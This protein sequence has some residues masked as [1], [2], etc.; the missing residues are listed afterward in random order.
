MHLFL[1][2]NH[3]VGKS[4]VINAAVE[5][6]P[7][8][9]MGFHTYISPVDSQGVSTVHISKYGEEQ[10]VDAPIVSVRDKREYTFTA[11]PEVFDTYGVN[12]LEQSK[13]AKLIVMDELGFMEK[14]ALLFQEK[15]IEVLNSKVPVLGVIKRDNYPFLNK[16]RSLVKTLEVTL[17]NREEIIEEVKSW[18]K[19]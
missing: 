1:M 12:I 9:P 5:N 10:K 16:V 8:T 4:T 18:L 14:E 15:V 2:G 13:N 19:F 6:L 7:Y 3:N 11:H 17:D